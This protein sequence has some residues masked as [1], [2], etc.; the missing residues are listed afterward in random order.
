MS[1][2]FIEDK[3]LKHAL[4]EIK[5]DFMGRS[6]KFVTDSGIFS[7]DHVDPASDILIN[8]ISLPEVNPGEAGSQAQALRLLDLGCGYGCIGIV[9]AKTHG[10]H[11]TQADV[12]PA[13]I[14]LTKHNCRVNNVDSVVLQSDCFNNI[15]GQ[16]DI[17]TLNPPIHAGKAVTYKMY[18]E[19]PAYLADGGKF[20]AVTLKKHGAEST[21]TKLKD[22]Y[23]NCE[24]IYKKKG[25][26]VLCCVKSV[27]NATD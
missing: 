16:F 11:L 7:K 15:E 18:E 22:I 23:G 27:D 10:L 4:K 13:A 14:N 24:V 26:Y 25:H 21:I 20:Y 19:S 3:S 1:H 8:N 6:F 12:N 17:I 2:Y 9:L 5:Y